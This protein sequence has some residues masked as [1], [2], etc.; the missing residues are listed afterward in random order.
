MRAAFI[1]F[2]KEEALV[3][4]PA[5]SHSKIFCSSPK[6]LGYWS[7]YQ[8]NAANPTISNLNVLLIVFLPLRTVTAEILLKDRYKKLLLLGLL[9]TA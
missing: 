8:S 3:T 2:W 5:F 9:C 6:P 7:Q 4:A 1:F